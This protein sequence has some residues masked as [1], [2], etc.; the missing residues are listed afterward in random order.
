M[1]KTLA[2]SGDQNE[3]CILIYCGITVG[4]MKTEN[5][6]RLFSKSNLVYSDNLKAYLIALLSKFELALIWDRTNLLIP[7]LLP[8]ELQR[9]DRPLVKVLIYLLIGHIIGSSANSV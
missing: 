7:S 4:I 8:A 5:L 3:V 6:D 9:H 2:P 1:T